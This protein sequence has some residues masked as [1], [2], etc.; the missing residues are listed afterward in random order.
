MLKYWK[1]VISNQVDNETAVLPIKDGII[2]INI[3]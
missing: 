3:V 2:N 1:N